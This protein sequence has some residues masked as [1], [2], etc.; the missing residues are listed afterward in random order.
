V[1]LVGHINFEINKLQLFLCAN[2]WLNL[3]QNHSDWKS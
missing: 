2:Q 1:L 3:H